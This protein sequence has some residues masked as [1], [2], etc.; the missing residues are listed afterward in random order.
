MFARCLATLAAALVFAFPAAAAED[1]VADLLQK[2]HTEEVL[3]EGNINDVPHFE[4]L[5][6][7]SA[8]H[9]IV[10]V[11]N[12]EAFRAINVNDPKDKKPNLATTQLR[13]L[14]VHDMLTKILPSMGATYIVRG[15][16]VEIVPPSYAARVTKSSVVENEE[17]IK[18]LA[19][20]L[21][22][23]VIKEKPLNEAVAQ[24]A[25]R[26]DLTVVV[27]PQAGDARMGFVTARLLNTPADKALELLAVQSDLRVVR[28]GTAF[29]ITSREHAEGMFAEQMEGTGED[30]TGQ[31]P[32]GPTAKAGTA[33]RAATASAIESRRNFRPET[34]RR[35]ASE[36]GEVMVGRTATKPRPGVN[37]LVGC[38]VIV[39][40]PGCPATV[41]SQ[42]PV[43]CA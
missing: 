15:K 4:L 8:K 11:I 33:T 35:S 2:L 43:R 30:R 31:V 3:F 23:A 12:E 26:F 5:Q 7:L 36:A 13:G 41:I 17:G 20:P 34:E 28:K 6:K 14:T 21:V 37:R 39:P 38:S 18:S 24:I 27:S 9:K 1:P 19:E 16:A 22:S 40:V 42:E 10:F 29:L 25:E 32:Q